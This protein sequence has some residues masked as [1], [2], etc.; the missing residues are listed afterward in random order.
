[1]LKIG[2]SNIKSKLLKK[3]NGNNQIKKETWRGKKTKQT[4]NRFGDSP[5]KCLNMVRRRIICELQWK[6]N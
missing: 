1:M 5:K 6:N 2:K 3:E 4:E